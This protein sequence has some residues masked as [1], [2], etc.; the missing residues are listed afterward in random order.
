MNTYLVYE[1][2]SGRIQKQVTCR[3]QDAPLQVAAGQ[4]FLVGLAHG[5]THYIAEGQVL[6]R[7]KLQVSLEGTQL[8]GVPSGA[9]ILIQGYEY[10]A[11]GSDIEL[12]FAYPGKY[13]ISITF[14]PYQEKTLE[15][16]A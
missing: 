4:S 16:E 13:S 7:P 5:D 8:R 12:E 2:D 14:W 11:D 6:P 15:I 10:T 9:T 1:T 3:E